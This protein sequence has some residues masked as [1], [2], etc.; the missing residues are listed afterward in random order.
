[1]QSSIYSA[2]KYIPIRGCIIVYLRHVYLEIYS[3]PDV[4]PIIDEYS[5]NL[6]DNIL[7]A[8]SAV[9]KYIHEFVNFQ[10]S[11]VHCAY[12]EYEFGLCSLTDC[13]EFDFKLRI[14]SP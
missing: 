3:L 2:I 7:K 9:Q 12:I 1:M 13:V 4:V 8:G 6:K 14:L 11:I 10:F 5:L